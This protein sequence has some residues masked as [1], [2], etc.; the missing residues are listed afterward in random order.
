MHASLKRCGWRVGRG[1]LCDRLPC[2]TSALHRFEGSLPRR[3]TDARIPLSPARLEPF[4]PWAELGLSVSVFVR[5]DGGRRELGRW[6]DCTTRA[7]FALWRSRRSH[8]TRSCAARLNRAAS[9]RRACSMPSRSGSSSHPRQGR[10]C[11]ATVLP[12]ICSG[13][14]RRPSFRS[15]PCSR[16]AGSSARAR[17]NRMRSIVCRCVA[18]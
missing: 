6:S 4:F 1:R 8:G 13:T 2:S 18:P 14:R 11:T 3:A 15:P 17:I 5:G 10:R 16:R 9:S 7:V 12:P